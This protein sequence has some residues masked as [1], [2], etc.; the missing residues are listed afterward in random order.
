MEARQ[1]AEKSAGNESTYKPKIN[2]VIDIDR[3]ALTVTDN[4]I[5]LDKDKFEQFLAPNFSFKTG[6]TRGH[7]GVGA[8][9]VAY[10]FNYMRVSTKVPGFNASGR[11]IGA[12]D[13]LKS[14]STGTNPKVEPDSSDYTD[15][16]FDKFDRGVSITVRFDENT[17]P[18]RLDW[19][20]ADN[21]SKWSKILA[22]KTGLGSV[23]PD[24]L[25][26]VSITVHANNNHTNIVTQGTSYLWLN[27]NAAKKASFKELRSK[28]D[29][30][31][32]KQGA[33]YKMPDQYKK[34]DFIYESWATEI[35][36]L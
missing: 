2:I 13:W 11:I 25:I 5:G 28:E 26:E 36:S 1:Q 3:N 10:G 31:F 9:Y 33:G 30:L 17:H 7:K 19:I 21:A 16:T 29:A 24:N 27:T 8:T 18:K 6:N 22:V 15:M 35:E 14:G 20:R 34:L 32:N 4:G 12:K 23:T